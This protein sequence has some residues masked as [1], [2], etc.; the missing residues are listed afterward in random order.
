MPELYTDEF[1]DWSF[2]SGISFTPDEQDMYLY[3]ADEFSNLLHFK[4]R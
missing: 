4:P 2:I 1:A 3:Y